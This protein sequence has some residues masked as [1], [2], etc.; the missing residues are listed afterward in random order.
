MAAI[1]SATGCPGSTGLSAGGE[2]TMRVR[3]LG[4]RTV[5]LPLVV[6]VLVIASSAPAATGGLALSLEESLDWLKGRLSRALR[7]EHG[8]TT[9]TRVVSLD[10]PS[11]CQLSYSDRMLVDGKP[12]AESRFSVSLA[13][14][15]PNDH[16]SGLLTPGVWQLEVP[17]RQRSALVQVCRGTPC[18][19][20]PRASAMRFLFDDVRM[21]PLASEV[22]AHA[23]RMC[24]A[25]SEI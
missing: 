10:F 11:R 4:F 7:I 13:D 9:Y 20:V 19:T 18:R 25:R 14:L 22:L 5:G 15:D 16:R 1:A 21:A 2:V 8:S 3:R 6:S 17:T 12:T 23:I 24:G